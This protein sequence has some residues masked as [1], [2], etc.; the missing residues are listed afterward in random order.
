VGWSSWHH[1]NVAKPGL[2]RLGVNHFSVAVFVDDFS[3][4][5]DK[6]GVADSSNHSHFT[7]WHSLEC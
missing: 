3:D 2:E 6:T 1:L 4:S 7:K 5:I